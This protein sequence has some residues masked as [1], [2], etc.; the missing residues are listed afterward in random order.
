MA[1]EVG[2]SSGAEGVRGVLPRARPWT[3]R[4]AHR[5]Q[6]PRRGNIAVVASKVLVASPRRNNHASDSRTRRASFTRTGVPF[7]SFRSVESR[8]ARFG[9]RGPLP[10]SCSSRGPRP[11][12]LEYRVIVPRNWIAEGQDRTA[13]SVFRWVICRCQSGERNSLKPASVR[14]R[15]AAKISAPR[16]DGVALRLA[17]RRA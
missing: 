2:E 9:L 1:C 15:S 3:A 8:Q 16:R 11:P 5:A 10:D 12:R 6:H 4:P 13:Y 14:R 17:Y 7:A